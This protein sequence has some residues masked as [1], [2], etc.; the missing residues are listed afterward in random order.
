MDLFDGSEGI[1]TKE[2]SSVQRF[3]VKEDYGL[4]PALNT[5]SSL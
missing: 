5:F 4:S 3:T 2:K 1:G